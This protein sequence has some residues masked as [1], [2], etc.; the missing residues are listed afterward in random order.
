VAHIRLSRPGSGLGLSNFTLG[1]NTL[2]QNMAHTRQSRPDSCLGLSHFTLGQ[3]TLGQNMAHMRQSRPESGLDLKVRVFH[4]LKFSSLRSEA[5]TLNFA[6]YR[7]TSLIK[8]CL[9]LGP[10]RRPM[11]RTLRWS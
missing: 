6:A 7:G 10:Y 5:E 9:L 2:C 11:P 1:E 8:N 4:I 3:N